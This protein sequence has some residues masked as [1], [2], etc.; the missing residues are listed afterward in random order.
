MSINP[1]PTLPEFEY[2]RPTTIEAASEFLLEHKGEARPLS[3]GT[4]IF[5]RLR[6]GIWKD[7]YLVDIKHLDGM[8]ELTFDP[9]GGLTIGAAVNMNR[10]ADSPTVQEHYGVLAEA[11][12]SCASYPL[13]TRATIVGNICNASPTGDTIGACMLLDGVLHIH[14]VRGDRK[15][16]LAQFFAGPGQTKLGPGD[17]VTSIHFPLPPA[18]MKGKY[19]KHG[20]N[21]LSDLAIVGVTAVGAPD[22]TA[23]SGFRIR[24]A[25]ASVAPTPLIV[26][27]AERILRE[28]PVTVETISE[29]AR[30]AETACN[31]IDDV[32]GS[33]RYRKHMVRNLQS[34]HCTRSGSNSLDRCLGS[35]GAP[36][37]TA[38]GHGRNA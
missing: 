31:P 23:P 24:V 2:I 3:G 14:G 32:R 7:R 28:R 4:D 6:D 35:H 33:A 16:P 21:Q 20:R 37:S 38:P 30:A 18:G 10:I 13:R 5:V 12:R 29:A 1:H 17:L 11:A 34:V 22:R 27:E 9:S 15:E 25:L 8:K 19:I 26:E 36:H